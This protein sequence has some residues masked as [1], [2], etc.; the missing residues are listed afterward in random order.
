MLAWYDVIHWLQRQAL[1]L[2][3]LNERTTG[4]PQGSILG[5]SYSYY[6]SLISQTYYWATKCTIFADDTQDLQAN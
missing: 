5:P 4:V 6:T 2:L 3:A 1:A